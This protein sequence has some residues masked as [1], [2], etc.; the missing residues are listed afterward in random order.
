M[1]RRKIIR[2]KPGVSTVSSMVGCTER[3]TEQVIIFKLSEGRRFPP[4]QSCVLIGE[5]MM[6]GQRLEHHS[7]TTKSGHT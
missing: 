7:I 5:V 4:N 3:F 2:R 1:Y 6:K